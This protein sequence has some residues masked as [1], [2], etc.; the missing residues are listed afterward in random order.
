MLYF[1]LLN[2]LFDRY[3]TLSSVVLTFVPEIHLA[4]TL[5]LNKHQY[6]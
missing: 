4:V 2:I 3:L 1:M 6:L 5:M